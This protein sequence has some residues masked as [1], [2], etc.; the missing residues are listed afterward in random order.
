[1]EF[2]STCNQSPEPDTDD[3]LDALD[4]TILEDEELIDETELEEETTLLS[5]DCELSTLDELLDSGAELLEIA[6]LLMLEALLTGALLLTELEELDVVS[7]QAVETPPCP[8][9]LLQVSSP[10]QAPPFS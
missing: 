3:T 6:T 10:I 8:H 7:P 5:E 1:M 9:W 4:E 2:P